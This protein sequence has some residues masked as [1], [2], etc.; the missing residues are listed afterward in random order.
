MRSLSSASLFA[1]LFLL[2]VRIGVAQ[3]P[4]AN[5]DDP[6][7]GGGVTTSPCRVNQDPH[8]NI[9]HI[10]QD[11][12]RGL[13]IHKVNPSYPKA[14]RRAHIEGTVVLCAS[15][16]KEGTIEN[17]T[18]ASGPPELISPSLKAVKQWRY[19]PYL[20]DG[21]P[22]KVETEIRVNYVLNN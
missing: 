5:V 12:T 10:K 19:K 1:A 9:V 4:P 22:V 6:S 18:V 15:I 20:L 2:S 3:Q 14:A 17:L 11:V 13:L 21:N 16:S 8:N 7:N